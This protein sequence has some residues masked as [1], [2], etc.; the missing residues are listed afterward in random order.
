ERGEVAAPAKR[1]GAARRA[2]L[3]VVALALALGA[4]FVA[5]A[6]GRADRLVADGSRLLERDDF[7]GAIAAFTDAIALEPSSAAP[8]SERAWARCFE[9]S[10][11][12]RTSE[13]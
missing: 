13:G 6:R 1:S 11:H 5:R 8:W 2:L 4:L 3:L 7:R 9:G 10:L 12:G